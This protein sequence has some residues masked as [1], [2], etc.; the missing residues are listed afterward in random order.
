MTDIEESSPARPQMQVLPH[1][2]T[3]KELWQ[4]KEF[5]D[6][7][8]SYQRGKVWKPRHKQAM[9][10]TMLGGGNIPSL[11]GYTE[12]DEHGN[13]YYFITDGQQ[14]LSTI[15]EFVGGV[16]RTWTTAQKRKLDP[17][18]PAPV[19][20]DKYFDQLDG[21]TK[22]IFLSYVIKIDIEPKQEMNT[23]R[24][25]FRHRQNQMPLKSPEL[26]ATYES[27]AKDVAIMLEGNEFWNDFFLG[28]ER[29]RRE[30]LQ[31][32]YHL[33]GLE[34]VHSHMVDLKATNFITNLAA[35]KKDDDITE[36]LVAR[37]EHRIHMMEIVYA[38][39]HFTIRNAVIPMYQAICFLEEAGIRIHPEQDRGK[40]A[41]WLTGIIQESRNAVGQVGWEKQLPL[42][43]AKIKQ[44]IFWERHRRHVLKCFGLQ[45]AVIQS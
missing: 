7:Y 28:T 14:R 30:I 43:T 38:G 24:A 12:V 21:R 32:C 1:P 11:T 37:I 40:L 31:S 45:D 6:N 29:R 19:C 27:H 22:N 10:D 39:A 25:N 18:S 5:Y 17:G 8:P 2:V 42:M 33:I 23:A 26:L 35:G 36:E 41:A 16:F 44:T 34:L 13:I 20:P 15:L 3:I 4:S 9:I